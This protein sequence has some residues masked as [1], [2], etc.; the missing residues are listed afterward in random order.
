MI[1]ELKEL[2][3]N[4]YEQ[5][6]RIDITIFFVNIF[7]LLC[8]TFFMIMYII[9]G[10]KFMIIYSAVT[11][12]YYIYSIPNCYKNIER[13][14]GIT[15]LEIWVQLIC[16]VLSFGWTPCYQNW[17]FGMIVAYFLPVFNKD[18]KF[19]KQRPLYYAL[20]IIFSFFFLATFFPLV[21]LKMTMELNIYMNSILFIA[22][23]LFVFIAI[24]LFT[25]FYTTNNDRRE[26][27]LSRK[28]DY[29]ELT[30]LYNRHALNEIGNSIINEAKANKKSYSVAIL[31][32]DHFKKINDK[33]GHA[34]GDLVL[35]RLANIMKI[36]SDKGITCGRWGGEEFIMIAPHH[37]R[38]ST[39]TKTLEDMRIKI[40][41]IKFNLE[42]NDKINITIS[43]GASKLRKYKDLDTAVS[44]ADVNLYEAKETGRNRLVK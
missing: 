7:V 32:I 9:I 33:Y 26:R 38:Y 31:D 27:K 4:K 14:M 6:G 12:L 1:E 36:Y 30:N 37:M 5:Q 11:L 2:W 21:N 15:F 23:N 42:N 41:E 34:S 28:A 3:T 10:H 20:M 16:G 43:I 35:K 40:S 13:Y 8:H 29:D 44:A 19:S 22:N 18:N 17:S 25:I 39:F 24:M